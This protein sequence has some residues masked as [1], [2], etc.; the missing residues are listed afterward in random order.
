MN[1]WENLSSP[2]IRGT[3][4]DDVEH[5]LRLNE[6][7]VEVT[8]LMGARLYRSLA[9]EASLDIVAELDGNVVGFLLALRSGANYDNQNYSWFS[10]RFDEFVYVD[11]VIVDNRFQGWGIGQE[12]YSHLIGWS[13]GQELK[14]IAAEIDLE[15]P[16]PASLRFHEKF[17]FEQVSTRVLTNG[18]TVSMRLKELKGSPKE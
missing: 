6:E 15:P 8:S 11:R 12:L 5:V 13:L 2:V 7:A 17:G 4:A 18:K 14:L 16:N 9:Q 3:N 10:Q 1:A